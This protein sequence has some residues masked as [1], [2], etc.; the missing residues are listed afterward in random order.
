MHIIYKY[1]TYYNTS[2]LIK[3]QMKPLIT[4]PFYVTLVKKNLLLEKILRHM[5]FKESRIAHTLVTI[6][7]CHLG[8]SLTYSKVFISFGLLSVAL[9]GI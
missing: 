2:H 4:L 6:D 9:L 5:L 8:I 3:T 7:A 1:L